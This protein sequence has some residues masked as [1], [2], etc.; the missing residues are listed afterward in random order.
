MTP[1]PVEVAPN[2]TPGPSP[3]ATPLPLPAALRWRLRPEDIAAYEAIMRDC[4][5]RRRNSPSPGG[6]RSTIVVSCETSS[7]LEIECR[8][9]RANSVRLKLECDQKDPSV[10]TNCRKVRDSFLHE[11]EHLRQMCQEYDYFS[12]Q[13]CNEWNDRWHSLFAD[14]CKEIAARCAMP[15][16]RGCEGGRPTNPNAYASTCTQVADSIVANQDSDYDMDNWWMIP[17]CNALGNQAIQLCKDL[18]RRGD[19]IRGRYVSVDPVIPDLIPP[20][21]IL[22]SSAISG[23]H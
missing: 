20:S 10:N 7:E 2:V 13:S 14:I 5:E 11:L 21:P 18:L 16:V 3:S 8:H 6:S 23:R 12:E 4:K 15:P 17:K 22:P 1:V 19:C 9:G